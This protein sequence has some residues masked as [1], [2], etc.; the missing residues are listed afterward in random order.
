MNTTNNNPLVSVGIPIVKSSYLTSAI[1]SCLNQDYKNMEIIILNNAESKEVGDEIESIVKKHKDIRIKY[2]RNTKQLP[3][4]ENWNKVLSYSAG[5]LFSLLCDDD[6][7]EPLFIQ[8]MVNLAIKYPN[9]NLFHSRVLISKVYGNNNNFF[10]STL[11]NEY[12]D[13]LDF[14]YHRIKG[15]RHQYL[16]DFMVRL[17]SI[18]RI[19]GFIDLPDGWGSDDI[20]WFLVAASGD[21]VAYDSELLFLYRDHEQSVSNLK[22][23]TNKLK[24]LAIYVNYVLSILSNIEE[25]NKI[26]SI[27]KNA[28]IMELKNYEYRSYI[29]LL[30]KKIAVNFFVPTLFIPFFVTFHKTLR[31]VKLKKNQI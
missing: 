21:G 14:I 22:N 9:I 26:E 12:E 20:T 23:Y 2:F 6:Y 30:Q 25:T 10:L 16:S 18:R 7:W 29:G 27:K 8:K 19:G 13:T 15:F 31:K 1:E 24:S 11:C 17:S 4:V 3:M 28:I 5:D